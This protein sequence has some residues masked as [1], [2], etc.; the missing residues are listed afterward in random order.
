MAKSDAQAGIRSQ[1]SVPCPIDLVSALVVPAWVKEID[2]QACVCVLVMQDGSHDRLPVVTVHLA[3]TWALFPLP[4]FHL[5]QATDQKALLGSRSL[6]FQ[7]N[8]RAQ[9]QP[10]HALAWFACWTNVYILFSPP[11]LERKQAPL[12]LASASTQAKEYFLIPLE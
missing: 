8:A 9:R 2:A 4:S 5:P 11:C 1:H 7:T 6:S 12:D 10:V 3:G